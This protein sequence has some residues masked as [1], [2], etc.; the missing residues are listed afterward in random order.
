MTGKCWFPRLSDKK[1][2]FIGRRHRN[3][4]CETQIN[5][6]NRVE[7]SDSSRLGL[8]SFNVD[9]LG[10][11]ARAFAVIRKVFPFS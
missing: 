5:I 7:I 6:P 1:P 11:T 3:G 9:V 2:S 8:A 4:G 10:M